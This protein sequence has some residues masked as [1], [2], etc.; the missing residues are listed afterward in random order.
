MLKRSG[1]QVLV[2]P[3]SDHLQANLQAGETRKSGEGLLPKQRTS[4]R[5]LHQ[6]LQRRRNKIA[7]D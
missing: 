6:A 3:D 4:L 2:D 1:E 7:D 5:S